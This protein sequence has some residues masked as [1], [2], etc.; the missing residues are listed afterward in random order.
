MSTGPVTAARDGPEPLSPS[1]GMNAISADA[2]F[3]N[4]LARLAAVVDSTGLSARLDGLAR[5]LAAPVN[6]AVHGCPGV[7]VRTVTS[8]LAGAGIGIAPEDSEAEIGVRVVTE[9]IKPEDHAALRAARPAVIVLNKADLAGFTAAGPMTEA[10]RRCR[11]IAGSVG[12]PA[13]PMVALLAEAAQD[14]AVDD[15][16]ST[17]LRLLVDEPG[18]L[19]TPDAF[20]AGP[21]RLSRADRWRLLE[22]LDLYGIAHAVAVLR[23][24]PELEP[25]RLRALFRRFSGIDAVITCIEAAAAGVRYRRIGETVVDL[26]TLAVGDPGVAGFLAADQ[27]VLAR[28]AAAEALLR[29]AGVGVDTAADTDALLRRAVRWRRYR[30]GPVNDVHRSCGSDIMRGSLRLLSESTGHR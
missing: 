11:Q 12:V 20:L 13:E 3:P 8:A 14:S 26:E 1:A 25:R 18:D 21:H 6:V 17:A 22:R 5:R 28:M 24:T 19:S 15:E 27:T 9:A 30:D 4:A 2:V 16:L 23:D 7:G 29:G 10:R